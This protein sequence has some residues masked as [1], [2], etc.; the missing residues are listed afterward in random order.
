MGRE[1][2]KHK[3]GDGKKRGRQKLGSPAASVDLDTSFLIS[4]GFDG[5]L[6]A[7]E[8]IPKEHLCWVGAEGRAVESPPS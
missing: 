8:I 3:A 2:Q 1:W 4:D 5:S 6:R 7:L